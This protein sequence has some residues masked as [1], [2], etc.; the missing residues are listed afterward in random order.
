ME[1]QPDRQK[2][3]VEATWGCWSIIADHERSSALAPA[4]RA[5]AAHEPNSRHCMF[6]LDF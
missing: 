6:G 5:T 1:Q 3:V 4:I 2:V